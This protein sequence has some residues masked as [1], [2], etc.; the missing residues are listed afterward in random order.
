VNDL[1]A[2]RGDAL[3]IEPTGF[4]SWEVEDLTL[5][6]IVP[7]SMPDIFVADMDPEQRADIIALLESG[8]QG[9]RFNNLV[10]AAAHTLLRG[11]PVHRAEASQKKWKELEALLPELAYPAGQEDIGYFYRNTKMLEQLGGIA[12]NMATQRSGPGI[13]TSDIKPVLL[14]ASGGVN[15]LRL[16]LRLIA[17]EVAFS[18]SG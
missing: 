2:E 10:Y 11:V 5:A 6:S 16:G 1:R 13:V 17:N 12:A 7:A 9:L 18:L 3:A 4:R 14:F 8:R 15:T